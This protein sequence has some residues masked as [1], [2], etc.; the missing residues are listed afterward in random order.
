MYYSLAG[1]KGG[2]QKCKHVAVTVARDKFEC[3]S[4][5]IEFSISINS[6][7]SE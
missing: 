2:G 5:Y 6:G 4:H 7:D 3:E 1:I